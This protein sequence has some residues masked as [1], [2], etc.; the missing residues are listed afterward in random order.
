[1]FSRNGA[2]CR[3]ILVEIRMETV[4][5]HIGEE[6]R[7]MTGRDPKKS[8]GSLE[9]FGWHGSKEEPWADFPSA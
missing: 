8:C 4:L 5:G 1:M 9:R 6:D 2:Q 7:P 3:D